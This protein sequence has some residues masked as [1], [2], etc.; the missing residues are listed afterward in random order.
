L[1][2]GEKRI[3]TNEDALPE[4]ASTVILNPNTVSY[5]NLFINGMLQPSNFYKVEE[6]RMT[7]LTSGALPENGVPVILQFVKIL[8][9]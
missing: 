8:S 9:G 7:L 1:S 5:V 4:Y 6:G 2:D 3:Y